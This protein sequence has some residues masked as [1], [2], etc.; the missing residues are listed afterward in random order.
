MNKAWENLGSQPRSKTTGKYIN[1]KKNNV[2]H[3]KRQLESQKKYKENDK[4]TE[5][6]MKIMPNLNML[7]NLIGHIIILLPGN[8]H[9]N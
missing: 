8:T 4:Y 9:G 3:R 1:K 2:F 7:T 6:T 5:F